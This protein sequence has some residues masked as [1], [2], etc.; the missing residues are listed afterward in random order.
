MTKFDFIAERALK[1]ATSYANYNKE[2]EIRVCHVIYSIVDDKLE[3]SVIRILME[4]NID[5]RLFK[6]SIEVKIE[7][8]PSNNLKKQKKLKNTKVLSEILKYAQTNPLMFSGKAETSVADIFLSCLEIEN[9]LSQCF[10][11]FSIDFDQ[12]KDIAYEIE[13]DMSV[14]YEEEGAFYISTTPNKLTHSKNYKTETIE[15]YCTN[16]TK[17]ASNNEITPCFGREMEMEQLYRVLLRSRKSNPMLIGREGVGKTNIVEGLAYNIVK[18][19]APVK[20]RDKQ[21]YTLNLNSLLSGTKYRGMFEERLEGI[22]EELTE[23]T[24]IILFIDEI[25]TIIGAGNAEGSS[26]MSNILKPYISRNGFKIIGATTTSEYKKYIEKDKAF[27]RRFSEILIE[28]PN[29]KTSIDI[30]N[31]LKPIYEKE[32]G[33]KYSDEAI[34]ACVMLSDKYMTY[35]TL[36]DKAIDLM[37]DVAVK[38]RM[39]VI[40][41]ETLVNLEK[42]YADLDLKKLKI[43]KSK[44][45]D[46]A[47][48]IKKE[49]NRLLIDIKREKVLIS[50]QESKVMEISAIDVKNIVSEITKIPMSD[51]G[52]DIKNLKPNLKKVIL[53]QDEAIDSIVKTLLINK[54]ELGDV[55]KPIGSFLFVGY[56]GVGKT[57]VTRELSNILF[58]SPKNLIRIDCSEYTQPHEISKLIGAPAGYVGYEEGGILTDAVKRQPFSVVLFDEIEKANSKMFDVLLQILGEGRLTDNMGE[59]ID[60]KNTIVILTSNVGTGKAISNKNSIGYSQPENAYDKN[61]VQ[62]EIIKRFKP[63]FINR[64]DNTIHFNVLSKEILT[65]LLNIE[66]EKLISQVE[67]HGVELQISSEVKLSLIDDTFIPEHGFRPLKRKIN[68]EV[69]F[70]VAEKLLDDGVKTI[71]LIIEDEK[72]KAV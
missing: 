11:D 48:V 29:T 24:N 35:R 45:Y 70:L 50:K 53:G 18:H 39:K 43:I 9:E 2:T 44:N 13:A 15:K 71:E 32:H 65:Q 59:T 47:D 37:D 40:R 67:K 60:F 58:N 46:N 27:K 31:K 54:L 4:L 64:I 36:P 25:H 62:K 16:I 68:D 1:R 12:F 8:I 5:L 57:Q 52:V 19:K 7:S 66:L 69:K 56:S 3:N 34:I 20:L 10:L 22:L 14:D 72:I 51:T 63:E 41:N 55:D 33:V 30:L 42:K 6:K 26:D 23:N 17:L 28:E 49:S 38:K 61:I 21:I